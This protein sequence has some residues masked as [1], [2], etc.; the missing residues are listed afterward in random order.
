MLEGQAFA[1]R[2]IRQLNYFTTKK[3][4]CLGK[5]K[6]LWVFNVDLG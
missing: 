4:L 6:P 2:G 3:T 1:C 5:N